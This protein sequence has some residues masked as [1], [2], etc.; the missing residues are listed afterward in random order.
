MNI[1]PFTS[2]T[3]AFTIRFTSDGSIVNTGFELHT[4]CLAPPECAEVLDLAVTPGVTTA[5]V[6][7]NQGLFGSYN[8]ATVEYQAVGDTAWTLGFTT[9]ETYGALTG[10]DTLTAYNVRVIANCTEGDANPV[11]I[12]FTTSNYGCA[13]V[14][15]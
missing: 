15:I 1:G 3:G 2:N 7:W 14:D 4:A 11:T 6:T 5:F 9:T 13:E 10:L 12:S 8:G